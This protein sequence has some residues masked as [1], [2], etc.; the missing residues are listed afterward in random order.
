MLQ[1]GFSW[2]RLFPSFR[3]STFWCILLKPGIFYLYPT[4]ALQLS[5][6]SQTEVCTSFFS[7]YSRQVSHSP[8]AIRPLSKTTPIQSAGPTIPSETHPTMARFR[9]FR[10]CAALLALG[11][12]ALCKTCFASWFSAA[13]SGGWFGHWTP[14]WNGM[15][16]SSLEE[17]PI[18]FFFATKG[19]EAANLWWNTHQK[20]R[21]CFYL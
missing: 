11:L 18:S 20:K 14:K 2:P 4:S 5:I 10:T 1:L 13:K 19:L 8:L 15:L 7:R 9:G 16:I 17:L 12:L 21:K 3:P 6:N